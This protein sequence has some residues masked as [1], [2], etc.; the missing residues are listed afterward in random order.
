M[1]R[2]ARAKQQNISIPY[3]FLPAKEFQYTASAG[4]VQDSL[5]SLFSKFNA[6]YGLGRSMAIGAGME[7]LSSVTSGAFMPFVNTSVRLGSNLLF[8]GEYT[9]GVRRQGGS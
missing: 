5:L 7:Y 8:S 1:V 2:S 4:M 9:Y 6:N 3:N